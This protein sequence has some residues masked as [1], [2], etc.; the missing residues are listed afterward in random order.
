[1]NISRMEEQLAKLFMQVGVCEADTYRGAK[2]M[3][4]RQAYREE[5]QSGLRQVQPR[6]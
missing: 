6:E 2:Y 3:Q 4:A 5:V 1:M